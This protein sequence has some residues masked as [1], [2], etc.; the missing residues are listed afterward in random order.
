MASKA[1]RLRK[2]YEVKIGK[3]IVDKLSDKQIKIL[4]AFYNSLSDKEQSDLDSQIIMGRNNTELHEMAIGMIEEEEENTE[5]KMPEGLDDLLNEISGNKKTATK[6]KR[7][8]GRPKKKSSSPPP[9]AL[10]K[11]SKTENVDSRILQLLGLEDVFDLDY[12]DYAN[13]LK[14]K[15]IEV[16]KRS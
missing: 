1:E 15:L 4:S 5:D 10:T 9:G 14:E 6:P 11:Y 13:L 2:V 16:S 3:K 12:D 7:K 8:R